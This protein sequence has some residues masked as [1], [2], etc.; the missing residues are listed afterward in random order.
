MV[1][2]TQSGGGSKVIWPE[3]FH[4]PVPLV[5]SVSVFHAVGLP[6][7]STAVAYCHVPDQPAPA[8]CASVM[9]ISRNGSM[10]PTVVTVPAG[11]ILMLVVRPPCAAEV[12]SVGVLVPLL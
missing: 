4:P 1:A 11:P 3:V 8:P 9:F 12:T 2:V 6:F 10:Y 5:M 7:A